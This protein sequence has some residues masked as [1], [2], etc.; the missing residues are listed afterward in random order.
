MKT[1]DERFWEKVE[2]TLT[3]WIWTANRHPKGYGKFS[4]NGKST[5]AHHYSYS[6]IN[7]PVPKGLD[8]M[9]LCDNPPCVNPDHLRPGTRSENMRHAVEVGRCLGANTVLN[10]NRALLIKNLYK[11]GIRPKQISVALGIHIQTVCNVTSGHRW[12]NV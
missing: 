9:H 8:L 2:K 5:P 12:K 4:I 6:Q 7:G 11:S 1:I 3:C 10:P